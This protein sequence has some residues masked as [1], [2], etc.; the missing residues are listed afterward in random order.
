MSFFDGACGTS[1]SQMDGDDVR[2]IAGDSGDLT[3]S[4]GD[5]SV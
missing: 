5:V 2:C 1:V 3:V 4:M